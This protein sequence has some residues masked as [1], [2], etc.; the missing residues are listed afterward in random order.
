MNATEIKLD[1]LTMEEAANLVK[2]FAYNQVQTT[3]QYNS[4]KGVQNKGTAKQER[5]LIAELLYR[6][7]E[8]EPTP[9]QIES[10]VFG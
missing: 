7:T 6:L 5:K 10:A 3:H 8:K 9:E 2:R 1:K 4:R